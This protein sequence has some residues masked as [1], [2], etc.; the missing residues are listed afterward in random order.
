MT[1][2]FDFLKEMWQNHPQVFYLFAAWYIYTCAVQALPKPDPANDKFYRW[3]YEFLH[4]LAGNWG[5]IVKA[6]QDRRWQKALE[7]DNEK[8]K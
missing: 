3:F 5:L 6:V 1:G 8:T 2:I 7:G 4:S